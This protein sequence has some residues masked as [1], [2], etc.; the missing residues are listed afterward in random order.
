M[1][2][3]IINFVDWKGHAAAEA[4]FVVILSHGHRYEAKDVVYSQEGLP[5]ATDEIEEMFSND[6]AKD[7]VG[8]PKVFVYQACRG[9]SP[10]R[11]RKR[12]DSGGSLETDGPVRHKFSDM[13]ILRSTVP[14]K[15]KF[16]V[17]G[18]NWPQ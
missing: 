11:A 3:K 12:G 2:Q 15:L 9:D 17:R 14:G 4:C 5:I 8:K 6:I 10:D 13:L 18:R 7:L 1:L 16:E